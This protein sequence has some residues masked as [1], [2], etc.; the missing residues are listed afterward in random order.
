MKPVVR[1]RDPAA[2]LFA[3]DMHLGAH[4]PQT[5]RQFL[6]ALAVAAKGISHLFLLGD[7]LDAWVGD[8]APDEAAD[9]L[10]S[11]LAGL[12]RQGLW[13]GLQRGNRDFLIDVPIEHCEP[14]SRRCGAQLLDDPAIIDLLGRP[15]M[16]AH[17]DAW[18][19][20]DRD[21]IAFRSQVRESSWQRR[22]LG[23]PLAER[24]E[25][26]RNMR[27]ESQSRRQITD[28][29]PAHTANL[30]RAHGVGWLIHGHTHQPGQSSLETTGDGTSPQ[31]WVLPD[32][33]AEE[34]RG[35]FLRVDA[36][37]WRW[38]QAP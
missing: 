29:D 30:M 6:A 38:L 5:L 25:I 8:D 32:W 35:G 20:S 2:A 4:D 24:L 19:L 7:L 27:A 31:R 23:K 3:S 36:Q 33:S 10:A 15:V 28:I 18:C 14:F 37:G 9:E 1:L 22:F 12:A 11:A 34:A 26:A 16:L 21:Y 17:G 13:I